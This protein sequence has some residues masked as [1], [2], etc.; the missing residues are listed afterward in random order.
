MVSLRLSLSLI[1]VLGAL[2]SAGCAGSAAETTNSASSEVESQKPTPAM[3]SDT[4]D[5]S[6]ETSSATTVAPP[7]IE[8]RQNHVEPPQ[9][10]KDCKFDVVSGNTRIT[11]GFEAVVLSSPIDSTSPENAKTATA[12]TLHSWRNN[13]WS[14]KSTGEETITLGESPVQLQ[15]IHRTRQG[16]EDDTL[17]GM[18]LHPKRHT[19][20]LILCRVPTG[21]AVEATHCQAHAEMMVEYAR[22]IQVTSVFMQGELVELPSHCH[23]GEQ[24]VRCERN[25]VSW[26]DYP[27][28]TSERVFKGTEAGLRA[29]LEARGAAIVDRPISC[30]VAGTS[31]PCFSLEVTMPGGHRPMTMVMVFAELEGRKV[32]LTCD[33]IDPPNAEK[34]PE[35]CTYFFDATFGE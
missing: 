9:V 13:G 22:A 7:L 5:A 17:L 23:L 6:G 26:A 25:L 34:L 12:A 16:V 10:S 30:Q 11:C 14:L 24:S 35:P 28:S 4:S 21:A 8:A 15:R 33:V 3:Q 31:Q 27:E 1:S 18:I 29:N 32:R 20:R 19:Q 2:T